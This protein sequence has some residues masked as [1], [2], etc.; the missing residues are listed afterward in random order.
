MEGTVRIKYVREYKDGRCYFQRHRRGRK[1]RIA[2]PPD[3]PEFFAEYQR[4]LS[5]H[6]PATAGPVRPSTGTWRWLC[7]EYMKSAAY[8]RL[9]PI[10]QRTR[11]GILEH[12]WD[13]P[14]KPGSSMT[15]GMVRVE[16]MTPK[17][18]RVIRDRKDAAG[19]PE[20]AN[21]RVKAIRAVFKWAMKEELDEM[22][23]VA[24]NPARELDQIKTESGG[25]HS[26]EVEEVRQFE[27]RHPIGSKARLALALLMYTGV[28]R[29]DVVLLGKQHVRGGWL[30]FKPRKTR[31]AGVMIE[32]PVLPELQRVIDASP[33]G[34]LTFLV[35]EYGRPF[36]A[37]GWGSKMRQWCDEAG[38]PQCSAHGIRKAAAA[39]AAENGATTQQLM[40]IFGWLSL[41]EAERYTRAAQ[42]RRMAGDAMG[43]L[44]R[45]EI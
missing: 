33:C 24:V 8:K 6:Q 26:W 19:L 12:T 32:I 16:E 21:N 14:V 4:L 37:N 18:L 7:V 25:W 27:D 2:A 3:T 45:N 11:K 31:K 39:I 40:A 41:A 43:L 42:R 10:F 13:E 1:V 28:R 5:E 15:F 38:L 35:T 34:D 30:K 17:A 29:S 22:Q 44:V 36:T 23:R 9:D 20:A